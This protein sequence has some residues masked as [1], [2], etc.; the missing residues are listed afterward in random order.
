MFK[1]YFPAFFEEARKADNAVR[2]RDLHRAGALGQQHRCYR[3][4]VSDPQEGPD[5]EESSEGDRKKEK[6]RERKDERKKEKM[7]GR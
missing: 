2:A 5:A 4:D 6:M 7:K 3:E 1:F